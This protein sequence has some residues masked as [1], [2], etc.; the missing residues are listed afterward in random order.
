MFFYPQ[1]V[2]IFSRVG[3]F[4]GEYFA[5]CSTDVDEHVL[6][7]LVGIFKIFFILLFRIVLL[8]SLHYLFHAD[9]VD[10]LLVVIRL[11]VSAISPLCGENL[12][13]C[14]CGAEALRY[15]FWFGKYLCACTQVSC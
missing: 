10:R 14:G 13:W 12:V 3:F 15:F 9:L 6:D 5:Q 2:E 4:L 1:L 8:H 11:L 7:G